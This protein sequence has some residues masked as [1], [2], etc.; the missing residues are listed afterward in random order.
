MKLIFTILAML[1]MVIPP[2]LYAGPSRK[3]RV[4]LK[5]RRAIV[6]FLAAV[7]RERAEPVPNDW[8]PIPNNWAPVPDNWEPVPNG[9]RPVSGAVSAPIPNDWIPANTELSEPIPD[10]WIPADR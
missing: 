5:G 1:V 8:E 6:K 3:G 9:W 4:D 2:S 7:Q 10:G